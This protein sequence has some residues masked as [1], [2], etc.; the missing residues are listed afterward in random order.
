MSTKLIVDVS[1]GQFLRTQRLSKGYT[2]V[3]VVRLAHLLGSN[4]SESTYSK[5]EQGKRNIF[6]TDFVI[7]KVIL[8]FSYDSVFQE[9]ENSLDID[10]IR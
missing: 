5:I 3:D 8:N 7:L 9:F 10:L 2:Q 4:M 1:L 6:M